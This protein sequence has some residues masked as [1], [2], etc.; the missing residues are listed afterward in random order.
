MPV[1]SISGI[2]QEKVLPERDNVLNGSAVREGDL[3]GGGGVII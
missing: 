1:L 2:V 3:A